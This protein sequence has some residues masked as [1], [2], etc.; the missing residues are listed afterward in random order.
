MLVRGGALRLPALAAGAAGG[1]QAS[2][3]RGDGRAA[4]LRVVLVVCKLI[5]LFVLARVMN[6]GWRLAV[7]SRAGS[8]E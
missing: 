6:W 5:F 7:G 8:T 2:R 4:G 3:R 1:E